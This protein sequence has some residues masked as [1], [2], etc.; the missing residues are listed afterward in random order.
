LFQVYTGFYYN[1]L[2]ILKKKQL[3]SDIEYGNYIISERDKNDHAAI[4][5]LFKFPSAAEIIKRYRDIN[6]DTNLLFKRNVY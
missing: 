4:L 3:F 6:P 2:Q 1:D 5:P